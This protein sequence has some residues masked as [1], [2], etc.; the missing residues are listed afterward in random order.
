MFNKVLIKLTWKKWNIIY[1]L[2]RSEFKKIFVWLIL[3][4]NIRTKWYDFFFLAFFHHFDIQAN[5][6]DI[7]AESIVWKKLCLYHTSIYTSKY[8]TNFWYNI[9]VY[10]TIIIIL[11]FI[12]IRCYV[13][14]CVCCRPEVSKYFLS[15]ID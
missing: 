11:F 8:T 12:S 15:I 2:S 5:T 7:T 1:S 3:F 14:L 13:D 10:S 6:E 4:Q 9:C